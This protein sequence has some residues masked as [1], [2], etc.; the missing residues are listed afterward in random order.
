M[1]LIGVPLLIVPFAIYNFVAFLMPNVSWVEPLPSLHM[2]SGGDWAMAPGDILVVFSILVLFFEL[3]KATRVGMRTIIVHMLSAVLFAVC[4]VE[5][6]LVKEAAT[7]TF[8]ILLAITFVDM[9]A[10]FTISIRTAQRN[11]E[12]DNANKMTS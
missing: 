12:F 4:L 1:F 2:V 7:A 9:L 6:L 3:V 11:I 10:G 5:F 8:F